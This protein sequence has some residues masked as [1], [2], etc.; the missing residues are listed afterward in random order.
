MPNGGITP[1][2]IHCKYFRQGKL[3]IESDFSCTFHDILLASPIRAFCKNY[4]VSES[5]DITKLDLEL[6][7]EDLADDQMYIWL[8]GHDIAFFHVPLA[9]IEE[10][11]DWTREKFLDEY[12]ELQNK[13]GGI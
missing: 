11:K 9:S 3:H 13:H 2:C 4:A 6:E 1:D 10:Y 5:P 7:R 8:G 12:A